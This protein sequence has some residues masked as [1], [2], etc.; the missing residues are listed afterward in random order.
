[1][2]RLLTA[3]III[4][5]L[6][7]SAQS[8]PAQVSGLTW[9]LQVYAVGTSP[10]TGTPFYSLTLPPAIVKCAIRQM[11]FKA[12]ASPLVNPTHLYWTQP[13]LR[14]QVCDAD[15]SKQAS[16]KALPAGGP[17]PFSLTAINAAGEAVPTAGLDPFT[18]Q[19][20]PFAVGLLMIT[21]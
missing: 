10:T 16:F 6:L 19:S 8:T 13:E 14:G 4:A 1:M 15:L 20:L 21:R 11:T 5:G 3:L 12:P 18:R 2:R 9:R 7:L 17:Y